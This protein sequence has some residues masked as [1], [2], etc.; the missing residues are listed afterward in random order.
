MQLIGTHTLWHTSTPVNG[1]AYICQRD[2][3][4]KGMFSPSFNK[5]YGVFLRDKQFRN[6]NK[7]VHIMW[8]SC[9]YRVAYMVT[10]N[11]YKASKFENG[12]IT[13][14]LTQRFKEQNFIEDLSLHFIYHHTH[15]NSPRAS[16][17]PYKS[18]VRVYFKTNLTQL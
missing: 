12:D 8:L 10:I 14:A 17:S 13:V 3:L 4:L 11:G 2:M 5:F 16:K 1:L 7:S 18:F 6:C 9:G 15:T